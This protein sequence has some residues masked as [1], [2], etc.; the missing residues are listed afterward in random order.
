MCVRHGRPNLAAHAVC[1]IPR[2]KG[3]VDVDV[4]SPAQ[5]EMESM[6]AGGALV[7]KANGRL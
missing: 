6:E 5:Q 7:Q 2:G 3:Y 4:Q 1:D